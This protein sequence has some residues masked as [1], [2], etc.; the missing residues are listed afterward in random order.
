MKI[1]SMVCPSCGAA[2]RVDVEQKNLV[3]DYCGSNLLVEDE[4]QHTRYGNAEET[5]YQFEK[6]R[7]RAQEEAG[8]NQTAY[9]NPGQPQAA[10]INPNLSQTAYVNPDQPPKKRRTWL[11]VLG[12]IFMFPLPLTI[13]VVRSRK[14]ETVI[15]IAIIAI[16]WVVYLAIGLLNK[17]TGPANDNSGNAT[18]EESSETAANACGPN[19][20]GFGESMEIYYGYQGIQGI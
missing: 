3:C 18:I 15:K 7:Q 9:V 17:D 13:L 6:G 12:W 20:A 8:R 11:W 10:F 4:E 5:G 1:V 14:M 2:L 16:A 19:A